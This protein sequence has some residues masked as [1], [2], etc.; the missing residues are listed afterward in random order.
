VSSNAARG[1]GAVV[2]VLLLVLLAACGGDRGSASRTTTRSPPPLELGAGAR[3]SET[4][5]YTDMALMS[6]APDV[7]EFAP[8]Y[9]LF[10]DGAEKRRWLRLPEAKKID[11]SVPD[12]WEFP[13]GALLFKEFAK[14][15][16]RI[17]TRVIAR[18]GAGDSDY[19]MG[20]FLW[21]ADESDATFVPEGVANALGTDHDVPSAAACWTCHAGE[22]GRVLGFSAVQ[23]PDAPAASFEAPPPLRF[24]PPGNETTQ[25]ALGYLH[26]NCGHCHN[27]TSSVVTASNVHFRL[28]I[29]TV[30]DIATT[31]TYMTAVGVTTPNT[32]N[33]HNTIVYPDEPGLS[34][35]LD[36]FRATDGNRMP[37]L[38]S[39]FMDAAGDPILDAWIEAI[40]P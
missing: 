35:L 3:L 15:G 30:D 40:P 36:R 21:N 13:V 7:V 22:P 34:V 2:V 14:G 31:A 4:G 9:E 29:D 18:S 28:A 33:G 20:A 5:L 32:V 27:A 6:L 11:A 24:S 10:S 16:R 12:H 37:Q 19:F 26:A 1:L 23:Q 17:E 39:E 8:A 38:G 25:A